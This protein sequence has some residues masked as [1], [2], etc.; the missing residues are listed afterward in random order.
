MTIENN[1]KFKAESIEPNPDRLLTDERLDEIWLSNSTAYGK[2]IMIAKAQLSRDLKFEQAR[3][4]R[5]FRE[6][7]QH[8]TTGGM[9]PHFDKF[10]LLITDVEWQALK[11]RFDISPSAQTGQ[12]VISNTDATLARIWSEDGSVGVATGVNKPEIIC[13]CGKPESECTC[14]E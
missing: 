14:E 4:E 3:I 9:S 11:Q 10:C 2:K 13:I 7:E 6:I 5:I 12:G 1:R 8:K